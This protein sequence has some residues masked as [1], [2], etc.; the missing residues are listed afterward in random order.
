MKFQWWTTLEDDALYLNGMLSLTGVDTSP[1]WYE[2]RM[3]IEFAEIDQEYEMREQV[4]FYGTPGSTFW[5]P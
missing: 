4:L 3:C 1:W 2:V 5:G